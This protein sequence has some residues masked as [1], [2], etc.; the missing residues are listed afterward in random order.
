MMSE[1]LTKI[2]EPTAVDDVRRVREKIAREHA[3]NL[4]Q[5][6][7]ETN[8]IAERLLTKL[9]VRISPASP[10]HPVQK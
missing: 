3:G 2:T 5:H 1:L 6:V 10:E 4:Q 9:N 7:E 8:Q